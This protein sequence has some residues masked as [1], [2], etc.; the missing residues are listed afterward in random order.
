V[1]FTQLLVD[2]ERGVT[3]R[4]QTVLTQKL[5]APEFVT[6][7]LG[8]ALLREREK[9]TGYERIASCPCGF[10][11]LFFLL[12]LSFAPTAVSSTYSLF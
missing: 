2:R 12:H 8:N 11:S 7:L 10:I 4:H 3:W 6:F 9:E 1:S 5:F